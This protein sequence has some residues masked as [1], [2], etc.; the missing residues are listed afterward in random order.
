M[1]DTACWAQTYVTPEMMTRAALDVVAYT[2]RKTLATL[3]EPMAR[4]FWWAQLDE[5]DTDGLPVRVR[6]ATKTPVPENTTWL[7]CRAQLA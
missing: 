1:I 7:I 5:V 3:D 4:C 2:E 6:W